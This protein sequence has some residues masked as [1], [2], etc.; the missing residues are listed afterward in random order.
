MDRSRRELTVAVVA[1]LAGAALA[2]LAVGRPWLEVAVRRTTTIPGRPDGFLVVTRELSGR[3]VAPAAGAWS[4]LALAGVVAVAAT[5]RSGRMV[6]GALVFAAGVTV[7]GL[8]L[9]VRWDPLGYATGALGPSDVLAARVTATGWTLAAA[10]AGAVLAATGALVAV[11]GRRWAVLSGRY[12]RRPAPAGA[13]PAEP[14]EAE[15]WD[16]LDRGDDS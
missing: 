3:A 13:E 7:G 8:A 16:A 4:L 10:G 9:R 12:A 15:L 5:R 2:L 1:C 11:R 6:T 14:T